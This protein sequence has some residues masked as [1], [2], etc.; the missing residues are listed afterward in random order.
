M[1][2]F[3]S[4]LQR[5][6]STASAASAA[7][8]DPASPHSQNLPC[9][10]RPPRTASPVE[11]THPWQP[12]EA[13]RLPRR[14]RVDRSVDTNVDRMDRADMHRDF[15][16]SRATCIQGNAIFSKTAN[17]ASFTSPKESK[18]ESQAYANYANYGQVA[19]GTIT[20]PT[21]HFPTARTDCNFFRSRPKSPKGKDTGHTTGATGAEK[22]T[23]PVPR[24]AKREPDTL[25]HLSH[26]SLPRLHGRDAMRSATSKTWTSLKDDL[27]T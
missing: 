25:S 24:S 2:V 11:I 19:S 23:S 21:T 26:L 15:Q 8:A 4:R 3:G 27:R 13:S 18:F 20:E 14:E 9:L 17:A 1:A 5:L 12:W 6:H 10:Q 22:R 16:G 7:S